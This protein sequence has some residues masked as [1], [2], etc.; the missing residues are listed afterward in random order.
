MTAKQL[1]SLS[2][3]LPVNNDML[4]KSET[5]TKWTVERMPQNGAIVE[6]KEKNNL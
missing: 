5:I 3:E 6:R 2:T 1:E 4:W